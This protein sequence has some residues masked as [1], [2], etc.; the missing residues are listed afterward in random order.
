M[1][2]GLSAYRNV[3]R[4]ANLAFKNDHFVLGQAKANI[5]KGF[6][7]GR[8][9]DPKD[10]DVKVRLE[11]ING[12]AYVLRTQVVQG[13]KHNPDEE[14]YQL[15]LHKDSEMG[16][17]ESIKSPPPMPTKGKKGKKVKCCSE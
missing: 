15:N 10:E 5:R 16:D 2:Q 11:H 1:S 4:A 14:K 13:Q 17:N 12:V 3:L 9:L 8:K 6:E 7:D